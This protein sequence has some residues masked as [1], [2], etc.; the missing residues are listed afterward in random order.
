MNLH[1]LFCP[2]QTIGADGGLL[3]LASLA[4]T[5]DDEAQ[6]RCAGFIQAQ[7]ERY[8]EDIDDGVTTADE[9]ASDRDS[10]DDSEP[11]E[12][13]ERLKNRTGKGKGKSSEKDRVAGEEFFHKFCSYS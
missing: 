9:T 11:K 7:I 2:T 3:P 8:A 12:A 10:S 13:G 5:L 1:I 6:Y 4:L